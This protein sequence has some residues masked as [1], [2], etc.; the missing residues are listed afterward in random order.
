MSPA[1]KAAQDAA[2]ATLRQAISMAHSQPAAAIAALEKLAN[3]YP[4]QPAILV[5]LALAQ[6]AAGQADACAASLERAVEVGPQDADALNNLANLRRSQGR[7]DDAIDLFRRADAVR[8]HDPV[9]TNNFLAA[10]RTRLRHAEAFERAVA[11]A[12]AKPQQREA[13]VAVTEAL[14][15]KRHGPAAVA[16]AQRLVDMAPTAASYAAL[17]RALE[18]DGQYAEAV[19]VARSAVALDGNDSA[20]LC[21]LVGTLTSLGLL[22]EANSHLDDL[23]RRFPDI[24]AR[25]LASRITLLQGPSLAAWRAYE[26]RFEIT[27]L[28]LPKVP[29]ARWRDEDVAGKRIMLVGEQ[30]QGDNVQFARAAWEIAARGGEV[31]LHLGAELA[32]LFSMLPQ[33]VTFASKIDPNSFD[34]WAPLL[35]APLALRAP[36]AGPNT[37]YIRP[38][39]DKV[40]PAAM[41]GPEFKVG[42]VWAGSPGHGQDYLRSCGLKALAPLLGRRDVRFFALQKG[43]AADQIT[44][45]WMA[46]LITDLGPQLQDWGDTAAAIAALDLIIAVDTSI[47]HVAGAMG[48]PVWTLLQ[49]APDW[50]WGVS[51][52][53]TGWYPSMRLFRQTTPLCWRAPVAAMATALEHLVRR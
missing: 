53:T 38:P 11:W 44:K 49:F 29:K 15:A 52:Q 6:L 23:H 10:L 27:Y 21:A 5:G 43:P 12:Q 8:P 2:N 13:W 37:P 36:W 34:M 46:P 35:S 14:I 51:G 28:K 33:G 24:D 32:P 40:A 45:D 9:V 22:E 3:L 41:A 17:S 25:V 30:G 4:D 1:L 50:R 7:L 19:R 18:C 42:L 26:H 47:V 39:P 16:T 31:I 20:A 48:K